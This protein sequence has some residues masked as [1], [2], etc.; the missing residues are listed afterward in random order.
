MKHA[1]Q[2][3]RTPRDQAQRALAIQR[4]EPVEQLPGNFQVEVDSEPDPN[5]FIH[6]GRAPYGQGTWTDARQ[7][8]IRFF[9][10]GQSA[11][12][13]FVKFFVTLDRAVDLRNIALVLNQDKLADSPN[14]RSGRSAGDS[15][16]IPRQIESWHVRCRTDQ[17]V[18]YVLPEV[19]LVSMPALWQIVALKLSSID[20]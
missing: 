13:A 8:K 2:V 19:G 14:V 17:S 20:R 6:F 4:F 10:D 7:R 3:R 15:Q 1:R 11:N 16:C 18:P 12:R 5:Q 9:P